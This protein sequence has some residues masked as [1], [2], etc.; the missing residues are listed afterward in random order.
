MLVS[1][2]GATRYWS[3]VSNTCVLCPANS[4]SIGSSCSCTET[5]QYWYPDI[6]QCKACPEGSSFSNNSCTCV[7]N[8]YFDMSSGSCLDYFSQNVSGSSPWGIW[9]AQSFSSVSPNVLVE[10]RG[11]G[12]DVTILGRGI[13]T[14][15]SSGNGA[16][17]LLYSLNG[18][19][20]NSMLWPAL[21]NEFT[22][23]SLTRYTSSSTTNRQR[24]LTNSATSCDWS[25][26][27]RGDKRGVAFYSALRTLDVSFGSPTDWLV[28]CG[29]NSQSNSDAIP[30]NIIADGCWLYSYYYLYFICKYISYKYYIH[31]S[32]YS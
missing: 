13:T 26:G 11:N 7:G 3:T 27:H 28:M 25:H 12:R 9:R 29:Q 16:M 23:C 19:T 6:N 15:N 5:D 14:S 22:I 10:A 17:G 30:R 8:T 24:I 20:I 21:P 18:G 31:I 1:V 4:T 32:R 2:C